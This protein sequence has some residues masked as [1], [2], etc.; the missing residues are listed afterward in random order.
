VPFPGSIAYQL[1]RI[2]DWRWNQ[3]RISSLSPHGRSSLGLSLV[4]SRTVALS[5]NDA[6]A[7]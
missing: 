1:D 7:Y 2:R 4:I 5:T 6:I 3:S